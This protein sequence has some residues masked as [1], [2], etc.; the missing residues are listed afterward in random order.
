QY[1]PPRIAIIEGVLRPISKHQQRDWLL[2]QILGKEGSR[3]AEIPRDELA[4]HAPAWQEIVNE[5][6][7][8]K[9]LLL[10]GA[11]VLI[12]PEAARQLPGFPF[13]DLDYPRTFVESF[14]SGFAVRKDAPFEFVRE[15]VRGA[16]AIEMEAAAVYRTIEDYKELVI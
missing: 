14:A 10:D 8:G 5:L 7:T 15:P 2:E 9:N 3:I 1:C 11:G 6:K 4:S 12:D 16:I 13:K